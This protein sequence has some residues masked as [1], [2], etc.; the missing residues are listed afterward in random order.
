MLMKKVKRVHCSPLVCLMLISCWAY[1]SDGDRPAYA[2]VLHGGAGTI[3]K[4]EMTAQKEAAY[5]AKLEE[6][7]RTGEAVLA[8]GGTS[9]DAVVATIQLMEDSPLFNAGKGAVFSA[10]GANELDASIMDG[11]NL[12]AGAVAGVK[13]IKSPI[14]LAR[15]VME[16]SKHVMFSGEGAE[17][18]AVSQ[19]MA[20]VDP[21]YF[22]TQRRWDSLQKVKQQEAKNKNPKKH[23]TVG[24]VALDQHGNLAAGTSTGGLTNKKFG[25]VGDSPI[26]GAGTYADNNTCG[27]SATGHGEYFIRAA[28]AH[29]IAAR[30]EYKGLSVQAAAD[31]VIRVKLVKMGGSGGVIVMDRKGKVAYS[32]NTAGM[33]RGY[34]KAGE[35]PHVEIYGE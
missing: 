5:R 12:A 34:L 16:N 6:A 28:V 3:L 8:K 35:Q 7:L 32:F 2:L 20:L 23:G 26:I 17:A 22:F 29:D 19:G 25:R 24:V 1:T 13:R 31:E 33:Y 15:L 10:E 18:F 27:V 21:K 14:A 9:L 4:S 11:S 30:V